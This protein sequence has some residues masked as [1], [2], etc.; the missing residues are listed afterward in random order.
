MEGITRNLCLQFHIRI[1]I[2]LIQRT[3]IRTTAEYLARD[4]YG[5]LL[6]AGQYCK[7]YDR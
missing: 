5:L 7:T 3:E 4:I 1:R 2:I 6:K